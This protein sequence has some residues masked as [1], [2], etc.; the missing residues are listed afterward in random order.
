MNE[1]QWYVRTKNGAS[2]PYSTQQL[3]EFAT[4]GKLP[5]HASIAKSDQGPWTIAEKA[6][7]LFPDKPQPDSTE[8]TEDDEIRASDFVPDL[9]KNSATALT[10]AVSGV[11]KSMNCLTHLLYHWGKPRRSVSIELDS[12][13]MLN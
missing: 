13:S 4:N 7:G 12:S 9:V 8:E 3:K 5:R 10:S 1:T 11:T 2:G 6:R